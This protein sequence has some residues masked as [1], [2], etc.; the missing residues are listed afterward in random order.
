MAKKKTDESQR[1]T[2]DPV[3]ARAVDLVKTY[4]ADDN[5]VVALNHVSVD[6]K[7]GQLTAIMGP[8]G[9]GKSTLMHCMAGLDTPTSGEVFVEGLEVSAMNQRQLTKLRRKEIGFIFQSFNLVP[10]LTAEENILLPLQIARRPIDRE[11]FDKVVRVVGLQDRLKHRPSQLSGGQQQRVACARAMMEQ[12]SVIFA[13]EPTGNLDSRSSREVLGFLQQSVREYGQSTIMIGIG[14]DHPWRS[15]HLTEGHWPKAD[16]QIALHSGALE[17]SGLKVGDR[18]KIVV[19]DGPKEVT[20]VGA[21]DTTTSQA[22][23]IIIAIDP[24][25]AKSIYE[26]QN[27]TTQV[28]DIGVYGSMTT[29]LDAEA[30]QRLAERINA[31]LPKSADAKAQTGDSVREEDSKSTR[32]LI[33]F[34]Q[35]LILIFACIALFVGSFIIAN[36]FTMIVRE[37]M[38]GYALLRSVGASPAQVF[39][40]VIVQAVVL[41]VVGSVI[42]VLLGWGM[43]ELIGWGMGR[44]GMPLSGSAAPTWG[45]ILIGVAVGILVS[46]IGAALP[47]RTAAT[48]PPIQAMNETVNPE[49]PVRARGWIGFAMVLCGGLLWWLAYV[50]ATAQGADPTPV[51]WVN[52][53]GSEWPMGIGAAL[54]VVGVIVLGAA[55]VGPAGKVLGWLP[56]KVFPVTGKLATRNIARAKRRTANTAAALFV[57]IAIVSCL[58]VVASSV[59][60]SVHGLVDNMLKA[61]YIVMP[62]SMSG[63]GLSDEAQQA[64]KDTEGVGKTA[65]VTGMLGVKADGESVMPVTTDEALFT[66]LAPPSEMDGNAAR[67]FRDGEA[68]IGERVADKYGWKLGQTIEFTAKNTVVDE[69]ATKAAQEAYQKQ[70]EAKATALQQEAQSLM[71]SGDASGAQVKA[72][73]AQKVVEDA[74]NVDP[75]TLVKT[76]EV[77]K[78]A[79]VKIGS[80]VSDSVYN[81]EIFVNSKVA[82]SFSEPTMRMT[83][84]M[85]VMAKPGASVAKLRTSLTDAV[86]KFYTVAV[87]DRD[88]FKSTMS[89]MINSVLAILYALLALSI[90]IA[91]FGIVNTLALNVSERTNEIGLLRAIGTSRG[92]VRGMLAIEAVILSVFGT[93]L[94]I[95]VGVGAGVVIRA[96]YSSSGMSQLAIPWSELVWFLVLSI[97]VGL[98]ASVS[99]ANRALKQPVLDAVKSE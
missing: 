12:P 95:V 97:V 68:V 44:A 51:A 89:T 26:D 33:G 80:I 38:R 41:G 32:E 67:A 27:H 81:S 22:G 17:Q 66:T 6:F 18:T 3:V 15:A 1:D 40:T 39:L 45:D 42:G 14:P 98:V 37:S 65:T 60:A 82:D 50:L 54:V 29:P 28:S 11:W 16:D 75:K 84:M 73:E 85:Y 49:K 79:K 36:T 57:G 9:S 92:Q 58:G 35:P 94:G 61:D 19:P 53:L 77:T 99:P 48:A 59:Q 25:L 71:L 88:Q 74:R 4:G 91:I 87:M 69:E 20:V 78:T 24:S 72:E 13:D 21:F 93:L 96:V 76:K 2:T 5:R 30:Q 46:V 31:K 52:D 7:R 47:A 90:V 34:I 64:V 63:G 62:A 70:V 43:L 55:L 56:E 10:T 8:S 23:A 83:T 86:K